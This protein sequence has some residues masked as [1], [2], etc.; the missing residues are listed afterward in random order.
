MAEEKKETTFHIESGNLETAINDVSQNVDAF[1]DSARVER[2]Y[3]EPIQTGETLIIPSAEVMV[4]M[5]FGLGVGY[6]RSEEESKDS[7]GG[8]G[9]GGGGW[10][11]S[12]PVALIIAT[13]ESVRVEPVF[14]R[15]KVALAALTAAGF[16]VGMIARMVR[17]R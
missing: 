17:G 3:G 13:P 11:L 5:G 6:G 14:D 2:V 8:A 16:M 15:T 4:G 7:G 10:T 12:R 9:G 1:L